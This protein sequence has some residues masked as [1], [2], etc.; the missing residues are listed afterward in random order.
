MLIKPIIYPQKDMNG[1][2]LVFG[3]LKTV[4]EEHQYPSL[5]INFQ[6]LRRETVRVP[7]Q[8]QQL[9]PLHLLQVVAAVV[10][11]AVDKVA[12]VAVWDLEVDVVAWEAVQETVYGLGSIMTK[13]N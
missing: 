13:T 8:W 11:E 1:A 7:L 3:M 4:E 10:R 12:A 2:L 5:S 6:N 9:K